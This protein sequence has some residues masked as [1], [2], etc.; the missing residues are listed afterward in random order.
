MAIRFNSC[1]GCIELRKGCLIIGYFS[2]VGNLLIAAL[3]LTSL[4]LSGYVAAEAENQDIQVD[5]GAAAIITVIILI[6]IFVGLGFNILLLIG[7][8]K[9]R[10]KYVKFYIFFTAI[11]VCVRIFLLILTLAFGTPFGEVITDIIAIGA[12]IYYLLIIN[13]YYMDMI[14]LEDRI[15]IIS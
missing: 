9:D 3:T 11:L 5:W 15:S 14:A 10:P 12:N 6:F 7:I 13:S 1:C 8:H 2:F 4:I